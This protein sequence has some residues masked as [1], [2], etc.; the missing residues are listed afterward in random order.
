MLLKVGRVEFSLAT[1][2]VAYA[3]QGA[4]PLPSATTFDEISINNSSP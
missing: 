4:V 3:V 2:E 1:L